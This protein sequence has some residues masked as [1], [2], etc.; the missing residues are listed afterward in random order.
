MS[1]H[2]RHLLV[3]SDCNFDVVATCATTS[4]RWRQTTANQRRSLVRLSTASSRWLVSSREQRHMGTIQGSE[5]VTQI[6]PWR[7]KYKWSLGSTSGKKLEIFTSR[8]KWGICD[9]RAVSAYTCWL[10]IQASNTSRSDLGSKTQPT[11]SNNLQYEWAHTYWWC[12]PPRV[13]C[14]C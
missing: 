14:L 6:E 13:K 12:Q 5:L 7:R 9:K 1:S 3:W 8:A 2:T 11:T 10:I 4:I